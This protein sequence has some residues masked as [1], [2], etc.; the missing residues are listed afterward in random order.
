MYGRAAHDRLIAS[1]DWR[2]QIDLTGHRYMLEDTR[3]GLSFLV[4]IGRWARVPTPLAE[5]FLAIAS[6]IT[7]RDL[8]SE[9]RT[10]EGL[11]LSNLSRNQ[12]TDLL[13]KGI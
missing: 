11:G 1:G 9:G 2:E 5:G 7:G 8:Y 4:S 12:M 6:A 13:Q 10:L 3:I